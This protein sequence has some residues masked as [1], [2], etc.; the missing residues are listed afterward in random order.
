M[1]DTWNGFRVV[2]A[3]EDDTVG[4]KPNN[5]GKSLS[6]ADKLQELLADVT[7]FY[8][9]VHEFHWNVTGPNF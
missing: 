4:Q 5:Q 7:L 2:A 3:V 1:T 8:H 9:T 6:L